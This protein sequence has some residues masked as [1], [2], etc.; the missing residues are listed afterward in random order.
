MLFAAGSLI[1]RLHFVGLIGGSRRLDLRALRYHDEIRHPSS[2]RS[3]EGPRSN[4]ETHFAF[5]CAPCIR[6]SGATWR[7]PPAPPPTHTPCCHRSIGLLHIVTFPS[8]ISAAAS[9]A[10]LCIT[11]R[12]C[13]WGVPLNFPTPRFTM[14]HRDE[15]ILVRPSH[16]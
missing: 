14:H 13:V 9:G 1:G 8:L 4:A 3:I 10:R 16:A 2:N 6:T 12:V 7:V 11:F 5:L 15:R